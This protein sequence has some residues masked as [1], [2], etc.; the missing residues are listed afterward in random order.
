MKPWMCSVQD[1]QTYNGDM[2]D[3]REIGA[4]HIFFLDQW[5]TGA[6]GSDATSGTEVIH[7]TINR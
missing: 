4:G 3:L 5:Q 2:W 1:T 7:F 6:V